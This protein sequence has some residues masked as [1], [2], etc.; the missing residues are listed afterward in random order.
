VRAGELAGSIHTEGAAVAAQLLVDV[1][2]A[3]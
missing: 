1:A 3:A 2:S